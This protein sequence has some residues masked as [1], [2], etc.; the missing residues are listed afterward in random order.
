MNK[1]K[2]RIILCLKSGRTVNKLGSCTW[3]SFK[4]AIHLLTC[5]GSVMTGVWDVGLRGRDDMRDQLQHPGLLG[6]LSE[7]TAGEFGLQ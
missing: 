2:V 3:C 1:N 4:G 7:C 6:D 5:D